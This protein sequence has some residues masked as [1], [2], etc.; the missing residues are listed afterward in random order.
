MPIDEHGTLITM[1][2]TVEDHIDTAG[3]KNGKDVLPHFDELHLNIRVMRSFT[4]GWVMPKSDDPFL[5]RARQ[6]FSQP[7]Q[8]RTSRPST[9]SHRIK[10]NEMDVCIVKCIIAFRS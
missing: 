4:I 6:I 5:R 2:M 1:T 9:G 3:L 8:H 10:T 7:F